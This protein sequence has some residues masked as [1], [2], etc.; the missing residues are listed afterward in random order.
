M[1]CFGRSEAV[2][3][4][5][6]VLQGISAAVVWTVGLALIVDT[7]GEAR[8]GQAMAYASS[9]MS[10]GLIL[11]PVLG[12]V[13]YDKRGYYAAF[14]L[15]FALIVFDLMLRVILVEKKIAVRY[16][17][18]AA[19]N[20]EESSTSLKLQPMQPV[21]QPQENDVAPRTPS[22]VRNVRECK[23]PPVIRILRYPRLLVALFLSFVQA[24]IL[25]AFDATLPL[26]LNALFGFTALQS[27]ISPYRSS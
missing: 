22:P 26:Y 16:D 24:T 18:V 3:I 4:V 7:V 21:Q 19:S 1:L 27:G 23:I 8:V 17:N 20:D 14:G 5:A 10:M 2:L 12:G 6:R 13:L 15:A 11:G 25:S 9:A